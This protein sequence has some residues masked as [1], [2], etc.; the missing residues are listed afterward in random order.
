MLKLDRQTILVRH[1]SNVVDK[2]ATQRAVWW[3]RAAPDPGF[4]SG[5]EVLRGD[6]RCQ[7]DLLGIGERLAGERLAGEG[8]ATEEA[9]PAFL[10]IEPARPGGDWHGVDA[11]W[12]RGW[13]ANHS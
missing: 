12:T 11:G 2:T 8:L 1:S 5:I 10:Q 4:G 3:R 9:P 7:V 6:P 13:A